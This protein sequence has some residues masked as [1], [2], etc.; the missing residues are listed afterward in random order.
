MY[1]MPSFKKFLNHILWSFGILLS[2]VATIDLFFNTWA[3]DHILPLWWGFVIFGIL[4]AFC[5][6][7]PKISH[8]CQVNNTDTSVE[9]RI[10]DIFDT[11]ETIIVGTNTTFDTTMENKIISP[12]SIQGQFTKKHC[13]SVSELDQKLSIGLQGHTPKQLTAQEKPYGKRGRYP[14][15]TVVKIDCQSRTAYFTAIAHMNKTETAHSNTQNILDALPELWEFIRTHGEPENICTPI[16]GS[17]FARVKAK[18]ETLVQEILRSF[19]AACSAGKFCEKITL[20][21]HPNDVKLGKIDFDNAVDFLKYICAYENKRI[22]SQSI[23]TSRSEIIEDNQHKKHI[24]ATCFLLENGGVFDA[25]KDF[26]AITENVAGSIEKAVPVLLEVNNF[27]EFI[28]KF[29]KSLNI[30]EN[31]HFKSPGELIESPYKTMSWGA[32]SYDFK[33]TKIW[34]LDSDNNVYLNE[35]AKNVFNEEFVKLKVSIESA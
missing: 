7:F 27:K 10:G 23:E 21:I 25:R 26:K 29:G 28:E 15:G 14:I 9:I 2:V 3:Q 20:Y 11:N 33:K 12:N 5:R 30:K 17:V 1:T 6:N 31:Q 22:G 24:K 32:L 8:E 16:I 18:K 13:A 4:I 34:A 19:V 35:D